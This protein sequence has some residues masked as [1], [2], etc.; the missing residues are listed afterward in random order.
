MKKSWGRIG[1]FYLVAAIAIIL[2]ILSLAVIP[3]NLSKEGTDNTKLYELFAEVNIDDAKIL[4]YPDTFGGFLGYTKVN[5]ENI[6]DKMTGVY[7]GI[8]K[9]YVLINKNPNPP[10]LYVY[11]K[12]G[13]VGSKITE[14]YESQITLSSLE[15]PPNE[16]TTYNFVGMSGNFYYLII[17]EKSEKTKTRQQYVVKG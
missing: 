17:I 13:E 15:I 3:N 16:G 9:I 5:L 7:T 8:D 14:V 6:F 12:S 4:N 1:Q 11:D 2:I 10:K